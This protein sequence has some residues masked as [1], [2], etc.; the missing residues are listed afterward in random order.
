[1]KKYLI[2]MAISGVVITLDQVTKLYIHTHF[3]HGESVPVMQSFFNL[4]YVRNTGAAFG[5]L[6]DA[7]E[8]LRTIF[9]L[10]VPPIAAIAILFLLRVRT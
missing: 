3:M 1:M 6:R 2:L 10:S 8:T 4:T 5:F 7:N 9:F